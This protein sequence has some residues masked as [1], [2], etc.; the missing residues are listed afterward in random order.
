MVVAERDQ[1]DEDVNE[2]AGRED[3]MER[4]DSNGKTR[5][6]QDLIEESK[7]CEVIR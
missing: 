7:T 1:E 2:V 4:K 3:R 5:K 6:N